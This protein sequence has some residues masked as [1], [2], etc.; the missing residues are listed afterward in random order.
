MTIAELKRAIESKR[1]VKEI[2]AKEKA[3]FDYTLADLI[4]RSVAR[5][6]S[7]SAKIPELYEAYP[8][9]FNGD[10]IEAQ[11]QERIMELSALRFKHFAESF[12]TKF[13]GEGKNQ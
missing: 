2:Q 9:L 6:Y 13:K 10:E 4:G 1:R 7:S 3:I 12:N 11:K 8:S 5:V